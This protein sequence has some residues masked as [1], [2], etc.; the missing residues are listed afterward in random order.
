VTQSSKLYRLPKKSNF[1]MVPIKQELQK[2]CISKT[3]DSCGLNLS[4]T[5]RM[6]D[7]LSNG[8]FMS[9]IVNRRTGE[10]AIPDPQVYRRYFLAFECVGV[11]K[12]DEDPYASADKWEE[13]ALIVMHAHPVLT[14]LHGGVSP[15]RLI[16]QGRYLLKI[17]GA[18]SILRILSTNSTENP[19]VVADAALNGSTFN[20]VELGTGH[21][22]LLATMCPPVKGVRC[23]GSDFSPKLIEVGRHYFPWIQLE[24]HTKAPAVPTG[25]AD[26]SRTASFCVS[27]SRM[28]ATTSWWGSAC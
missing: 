28:S 25:W 5:P 17:A 8:S 24:T 15:S 14:P 13:K 7:L 27:A 9:I 22:A 16:G 10:N 23:Y 19:Q 18:N 1:L 4:A 11:Y 12:P 6:G 20:I 26:L 2:L 21:A 3:F